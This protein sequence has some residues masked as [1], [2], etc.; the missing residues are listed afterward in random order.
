[1]CVLN[2][3]EQRY[4]MIFDWWQSDSLNEGRLTYPTELA[5][6]LMSSFQLLKGSRA[7]SSSVN[8]HPQKVLVL[9]SC[10]CHWELKRQLFLLIVAV[11]SSSGGTTNSTSNNSVIIVVV[12]IVVVVS[13]NYQAQWGNHFR[14][15]MFSSSGAQNN[16]F[17]VWGCV[18]LGLANQTKQ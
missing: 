18:A 16:H 2:H 10:H 13:L 15:I 4:I 14:V 12:V 11:I 6:K 9:N 7:A 17:H 3:P 1:M 8:W 5:M